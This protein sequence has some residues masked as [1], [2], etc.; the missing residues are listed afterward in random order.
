MDY[1]ALNK[2]TVPNKFPIPVIDELLDE[3]GP[4][5]VFSKIDLKSGYHQI[6][7]KAEDVEKTAF[8]T[9]EG[10]YEFI[11]MPFGLTNAPST[12]QALMNEVLR[13][14]LR[15]YALVFFDDIL[16]YSLTM[17]EHVFHLT[18]V[19][20]LMEQQDL[21]INGKKSV[22]GRQQIEYLGHI[23]SAGTVAADPKKLEAMWM[24]PVPKD[25]KSLRG[26]LGLTG[27]YRRFVR[28]YGKI[29]RP[30][31]QLLKKD[32]FLWGAEPQKAFEAL[33]QALTE[34]PSLAV[35]DFSKVFVLE[36]DASGTGLG[37]VLSQEGK[38]LAFWSATLSDRSQA[39]SVY[40]RELMAVVRAVQ[41]WRHYLM[42]RH[43]I[44]RTDQKSLKFLTEQQVLGEE[45]F[46]WISKLAGYDFEIQYKPG[47][48]NSAADAMSRRSSYCA[49]SVIKVN[50]LEEWQAELMQDDK[51]QAIM[52]D[53]IVDPDSHRGYTL[54]D[55]RLYY[56]GKLVL[57]KLSNKI[58]ILCKEFH[59]SLV[60]GHSGFFRTYR[61]LAAVVY[62]EGMK[63]DI[64]DFVAQCE[65]C[66]Q[67]KV[68][69]LSPAGLLQP[70]PIPTQVWTDVSMD[71]IGGLPKSKGK[72]T[73]LVVVDRLTKY[74]HFVP[75]SHPYTAP[76][77]AAAFL[78]EVVRLHGFP[79]TIVSDRDSVFLS[80]FWKE[81]FRLSGTKLKYSSAYHPQTDGQT[82][83][84]N[85]CLEVYLRCLTGS[86]PKQWVT[87]LPW[88]EFWFNSNYNR[89]TKMSPFQALYGRDPPL[90]LHGTTIPSKLEAVNVLQ[91]DR[92]ELLGDLRANL[93]K[94]QDM[95]RKYAN[96]SRRDVEYQVGDLVYLKLQ[97]YRRRSLAKKL[98][99]KLSPRFYGPFP[100][101][102]RI[103]TVAY[104][105]DLP[106]TSRIHPVFHV[107]LLK[108]AIGTGFQV[109]DLPSVLTEDHELLVEPEE[110]LAVRELTQGVVEVL[111][112][113]QSLPA[114]ENSWESAEKIHEAFPTFPLEDKVVL[115]GGGIDDS[116]IPKIPKSRFTKV[117]TR[118]H[119]GS[120]P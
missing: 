10:H 92:D 104:R 15:K 81:L 35:P 101:A 117:Y 25:L 28:D 47:K 19:L 23:L 118:K 30:L 44:I 73:I 64:R 65:V 59:A 8:R 40:V 51:L 37:A 46:K 76:D 106:P 78:Q 98:N 56:K 79:N 112:Q 55:H 120:K 24:W 61:R 91:A 6:M 77:V 67:N 95:M 94:S 96:K 71:F 115:L 87:C 63:G 26:F 97:P 116:S 69:N 99:E 52:Q 70:L 109:Q 114:C 34:L 74:A 72:D 102:A 50:D 83:V 84:V 42:G 66:Q 119:K 90:L 20:Q 18:Q 16:V 108:K 32:S 85:R 3:I 57:P 9:H 93:L 14:V 11:V 4:A 107:S 38:P 58:P 31:T 86:R 89:S 17:E 48:D 21:K 7:M 49:L 29:A 68:D 36:T 1:R 100:V 113:W 41:R 45:Q 82:E 43:F 27:Y 88:A 2:V 103:G 54:R 13:P 60:G 39:K 12:F 33:K 80:S 110:V 62:W 53:L 111:I 105:L 75:L 5:R 22:F